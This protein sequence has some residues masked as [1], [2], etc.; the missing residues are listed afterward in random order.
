MQ[1]NI[2]TVSAAY[3]FK[4]FCHISFKAKRLQ[5]KKFLPVGGSWLF[6]ISLGWRIGNK[7]LFKVDLT[8]NLN[9]KI[10][11]KNLVTIKRWDGVKNEKV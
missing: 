8:K 6:F 7:Q 5:K 9:Q 11:T 10:L 3:L 4:S 2:F 1:S